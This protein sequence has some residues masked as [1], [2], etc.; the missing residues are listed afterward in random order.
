[1]AF[2]KTLKT[3]IRDSNPRSHRSLLHASSSTVPFFPIPSPPPSLLSPPNPFSFVPVRTRFGPL[4]LSSPPWKLSQRT[5]PLYFC[6]RLVK[7]PRNLLQVRCL[8]IGLDFSSVANRRRNAKHL[9][10]EREK[11]LLDVGSAGINEN[12]LNLPNLVSIS[13]MVSGPVIGWY[14]QFFIINSF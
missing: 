10:S 5:N 2:F 9:N 4:F 11:L 8:P 7:F 14:D 6:G 12:F 13:R 1:M 3:L